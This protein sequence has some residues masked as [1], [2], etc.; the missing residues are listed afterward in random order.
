M[1]ISLDGRQLMGTGILHYL[2]A[3]REA[4]FSAAIFTFLLALQ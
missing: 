2:P 4:A 3:S 1:Q